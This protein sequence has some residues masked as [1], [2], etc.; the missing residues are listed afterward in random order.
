MKMKPILYLLLCTAL[1]LAACSSAVNLEGDYPMDMELT[2]S[3]FAAGER[4]PD[5]FTC[6]GENVSPPLEWSGVPETEAESLVL[7]VDDP[8][9]PVKTWV[10]WVVYNL[11]PDIPRLEKGSSGGGEIGRNDF[12]ELGYGGPCPPPGDAHTY[13]FKLYAL[14][15][16]LDLEAGAAKRDVE[17]AMQDHVLDLAELTGTFSR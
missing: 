11:P 14:D 1:G 17:L 16:T 10:H 4:I 12:K 3:A 15:T 6:E 5:Q 9:A 2:S 7:L 13:Q 8:D